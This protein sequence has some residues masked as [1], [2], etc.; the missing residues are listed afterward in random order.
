MSVVWRPWCYFFSL[1]FLCDA[2]SFFLRTFQHCLR[3]WKKSHFQFFFRHH[4]W[5]QGENLKKI[6]QKCRRS[7]W[8]NNTCIVCRWNH[9]FIRLKITFF[10]PPHWFAE[11]FEREKRYRKQIAKEIDENSAVPRIYIDNNTNKNL[12][13]SNDHDECMS[14]FTT[15]CFIPFLFG[16]SISFEWLPDTTLQILLGIFLFVSF[17]FISFCTKLIKI[18]AV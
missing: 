14:I 15:F 17:H 1:D 5:E 18:L 3:I 9:H 4:R 10:S 11:I 13:T 12:F 16:L 8:H 6:S 7:E 2:R